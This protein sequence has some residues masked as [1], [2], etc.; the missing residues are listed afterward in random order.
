MSQNIGFYPISDT[1]EKD[2]LEESNKHPWVLFLIYKMW[3]L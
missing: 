1:E 3:T 2:K